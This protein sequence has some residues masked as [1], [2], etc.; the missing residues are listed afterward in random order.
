MTELWASPEVPDHVMKEIKLVHD[1]PD[2]IEDSALAYHLIQEI[3]NRYLH[4][5]YFDTKDIE[6][7]V[8]GIRWEKES[9]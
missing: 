6:Q 7:I 2:D 8:D 1:V 4:A 5:S 9:T 3:I